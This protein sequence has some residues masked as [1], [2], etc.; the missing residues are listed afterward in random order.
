M[1]DA[2]QPCPYCEKC[3]DKGI[4]KVKEGQI[5]YYYYCDCKAGQYELNCDN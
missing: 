2:T 3:N 5:N 1:D 4:V